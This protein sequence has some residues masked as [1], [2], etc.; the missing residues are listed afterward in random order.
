[1]TGDRSVR[2][3]SEPPR[4]ASLAAARGAAHHLTMF[5]PVGTIRSAPLSPRTTKV[6][7]SYEMR[8]TTG[9]ATPAGLPMPDLST[10]R[11]GDE[12]AGQE[13][14]ECPMHFVY[15]PPPP[16]PPLP[17]PLPPPCARC[18]SPLVP[19]PLSTHVSDPC[20]LLEHLR[21][22][23]WPRCRLVARPH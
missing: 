3:T 7:W 5:R 20:F 18:L 23:L 14:G 11:C 17:P 21:S 12:E 13:A 4:A 16:P 19:S 8:A 22:E 9:L 1:F 15:F 10:V 6:T 2:L